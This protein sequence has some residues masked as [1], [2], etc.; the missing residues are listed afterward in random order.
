[1]AVGARSI[2]DSSFL[3]ALAVKRD[4]LHRWA[5]G[6][7]P[8]APG[9]WLTCEACISEAVF[10]IGEELGMTEV[11]KLYEK[12]EH[13]LI[14][15]ERIVPDRLDA[16]I[17]ESGRYHK[18]MVD[19]ADASLMVLSDL[20]PALPIVTADRNDF[21]VYLRNRPRRTLITR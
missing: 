7:L 19:F 11:L 4:P 1:M 6:S 21:A 5:V 10:L 20:H 13:G 9:P 2:V 16:V 3:A 17:V 8:R 12:V 18:R 15:C 14:E